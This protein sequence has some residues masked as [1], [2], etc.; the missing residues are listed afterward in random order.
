MSGSRL[1]RGSLRLITAAC[2]QRQAA[3]QK[4]GADQSDG[5]VKILL[6]LDTLD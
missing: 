5:A 4:S 6:L 1:A 2:V 3:D